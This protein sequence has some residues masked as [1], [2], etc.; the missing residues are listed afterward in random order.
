M[1]WGKG[2]ELSRNTCKGSMD[3]AKEGRF[4]QGGG[5][6]WGGWECWGENGDNCT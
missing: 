2:E 4:K 5:V 1:G 6:G 3:K